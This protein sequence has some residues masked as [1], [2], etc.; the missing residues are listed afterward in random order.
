MKVEVELGPSE[1][2]SQAVDSGI[3][4]GRTAVD[5][6]G[7]IRLIGLAEEVGCTLSVVHTNLSV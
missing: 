2:G 1:R 7:R 6:V 5:L 3:E 4:L